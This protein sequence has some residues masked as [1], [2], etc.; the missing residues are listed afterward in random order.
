MF[1]SFLLTHPIVTSRVFVI[2]PVE[3]VIG[4]VL[5]TVFGDPL[6]SIT[7]SLR[8][9]ARHHFLPLQVNLQPLAG[10]LDLG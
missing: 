2:D 6:V 5:N 9:D 7:T 3:A 4:A 8:Q 10:V 1:D